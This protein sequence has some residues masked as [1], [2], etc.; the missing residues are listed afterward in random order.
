M[1]R[2]GAGKGALSQ[3]RRL[4]AGGD[5]ECSHC[6]AGLGCTCTA[7]G[8]SKEQAP[9][10]GRSNPRECTKPRQP[11]TRKVL[12]TFCKGQQG[13]KENPDPHKS[14]SEDPVS[15]QI[16]PSPSGRCKR[17]GIFLAQMHMPPG[18][19]KCHIPSPNQPLTKS[20]HTRPLTNCQA[21]TAPPGWSQ[22]QLRLGMVGGGCCRVA[23]S[24]K[25]CQREENTQAV[26]KN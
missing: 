6:R 25:I 5:V 1:E 15:P 21:G 14:I 23:P 8:R 11:L 17:R 16:L 2:V 19:Q 4:S 20:H 12:S 13:C 7:T 22:R 3:S 10:L 18:L 26:L 24:H 9:G